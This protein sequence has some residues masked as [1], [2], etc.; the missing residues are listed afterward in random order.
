MAVAVLATVVLLAD[1]GAITATRLVA[2]GARAAIGTVGGALAARTVQM[3]AMPQL[4]SLFNAVGGGA[5][6][7]SRSPTCAG[8]AASCRPDHRARRR[9]TS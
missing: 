7:W 1:A 5:A 4:V 6:A 2:L 3:T 8:R 9:W